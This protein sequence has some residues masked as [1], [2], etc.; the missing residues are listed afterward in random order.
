MA[1][2]GDPAVSFVVPAKGEAAYLPAALDG[3]AAQ[4]TDREYETVVVVGGPRDGTAEVAAERGARVYRQSTSGIGNA[5]HLGACHARGDWLAFVDADTVPRP[6][7]VESMLDFVAGE[8]LAAASSRCRITG[9]LRAK[10]MEWTINHLFPRLSRPVLP[11]F[12]C[13]VDAA[14]YREAGGFPAVPNEDTAF[15][16][17]LGRLAE[18]G[19]CPAVLVETSGRRIADSGLTGTLYH[20]LRLDWGRLTA[21]Y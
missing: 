10:P 1:D 15:S 5:R 21:D 12:N 17:R 16:R 6:G 2:G 18:T 8:G 9:P 20:Y 3:I 7:Y 11:G 14:T 4:D 19:Y 13:F